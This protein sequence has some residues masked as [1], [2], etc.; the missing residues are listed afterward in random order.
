MTTGQYGDQELLSST[1]ALM[2]NTDVMVLHIDH[3]VATLYTTLA[4]TTGGTGAPYQ[5]VK[6]D[7]DGNLLFFADPNQYLL[8]V[9][10]TVI[11]EVSVSIPGAMIGVVGGIP[12]PLDGSG[13]IPSGQVPG[14]ATGNNA[15]INAGGTPYNVDRTGV[16]DGYTPVLGAIADCKTAGGGTVLLPPGTIKNATGPWLVDTPTVN[17]LGPAS[18]ALTIRPTFNG[19]CFRVKAASFVAEES[20]G[21][22][23]GFTIN[24]SAAGA[25]ACGIHIGDAMNGRLTDLR[26]RDFTG[27]SAKGIWCD[28]TGASTYTERWKWDRVNA[29]ANTIGVLFDVNSGASPVGIA[30]SFGYQDAS[31]HVV[32]N[33]GQVGIRLQNGANAYN[34]RWRIGGN[35]ANGGTFMQIAGIT[36]AGGTHLGGEHAIQV[37]LTGGG[38]G[39]GILLSEYGRMSGH[40]TVDLSSGTLTSANSIAGVHP[41]VFDLTGKILLPGAIGVANTTIGSGVPG[42]GGNVGDIYHRTDTPATALQR[43]YVCTVAGGAGV[44]TWV[45][46]L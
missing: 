1:G 20:F 7:G 46:I 30:K 11:K 39:G 12:G 10:G 37:E 21:A 13:K 28:N 43:L 34:G 6:T 14:L 31:L 9:D 45:G 25:S 15:I 29:V 3:S 22:F 19:D 41:G 2:P 40:G 42:I 23:G 27:A 5:P 44:A 26:V 35:I 8:E 32:V 4:G 16:V 24:G 33:S 36:G 18:G 17:V 38:S